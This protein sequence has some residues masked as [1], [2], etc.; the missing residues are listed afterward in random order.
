MGSSKTKKK[1]YHEPIG[2]DVIILQEEEYRPLGRML[3]FHYQVLKADSK[4]IFL[5]SNVHLIQEEPTKFVSILA[6]LVTHLQGIYGI[7]W[8]TNLSETSLT[9]C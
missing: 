7:W 2:S 4:K 3:Y 1:H 8:K 5:L 9:C 6:I